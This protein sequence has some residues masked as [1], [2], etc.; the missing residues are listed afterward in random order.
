VIRIESCWYNSEQ[1][2]IIGSI[3]ADTKRHLA[4]VYDNYIV[5]YPHRR[6]LHCWRSDRSI[7]C[8]TTLHKCHKTSR[9]LPNHVL[10]N[11]RCSHILW[12]FP[13]T[14]DQ[15]SFW[16]DWPGVC[17]SKEAVWLCMEALVRW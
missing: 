11:S 9:A 16:H 7:G 4:K 8:Y 13:M 14:Y 6:H 2:S 1:D 15:L 3:Q 10:P 12:L 17:T 5:L